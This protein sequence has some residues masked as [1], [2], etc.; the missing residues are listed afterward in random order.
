[1]QACADT[2]QRFEGTLDVVA[3]GKVVAQKRVRIA[4]P[5]CPVYSYSVKFV[6]GHQA[7]CGCAEGPVRPGT[8][9]TEI[10]LYNDGEDET[11][12]VKRVVPLVLAG[13]PAGR[14]PRTVPPRAQDAIVLPAKSATMDDS[15][16]LSELLFGVP[17]AGPLPLTLGFLEIASRQPL[18]V[19]AVYTVTGPEGG[20]VSIAVETVEPRIKRGRL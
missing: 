12:I 10:N 3:D 8:Y 7:D 6:Y 13:A 17:P 4:V 2:E 20:P 9:A 19:V 1:V 14:E 16:R 18:K 15:E 5:A 11:P